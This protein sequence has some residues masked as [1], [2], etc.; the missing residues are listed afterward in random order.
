MC[1][2]Y[3]LRQK[4]IC[5]S[6][7]G[8]CSSDRGT[9]ASEK[10][11][12]CLRKRHLLL[13]K[14]HLC[15][16]KSHL[17]LRKRHLYLRKRQFCLRKRQFCLGKRATRKVKA[18]HIKLAKLVPRSMLLCL[19][20]RF[21]GSNTFRHPDGSSVIEAFA[22]RGVLT[23]DFMIWLQRIPRQKLVDLPHYSLTWLD[24]YFD[25]T[26]FVT[27]LTSQIWPNQASSWGLSCNLRWH[28]LW[29]EV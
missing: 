26:K 16:R 14:R 27:W 15:H 10:G 19:G 3:V 18:F 25:W 8:T 11:H 1:V 29:L 13:R 7:R 17:C 6:E 28:N 23:I 24:S 2:N 20:T 4:G 21:P 9:F 22:A 12:F 5:A